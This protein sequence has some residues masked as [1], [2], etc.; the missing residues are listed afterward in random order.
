MLLA[1]HIGAAGV[2]WWL[3]PGGFP[4]SSTEFWVNQAA[5]PF[6]MALLLLALLARGRVSAVILPPV[7]AM[8]PAFWMAFGISAR[9]TF[10]ESFRSL[11]MLPFLAGAALAGLWV[12]GFMRRL[13]RGWLVPVFAVAALAAGWSFP[14]TQRAAA[15]ATNPTADPP[16]MM[17]AGGD[18]RLVKL[19][20]DAQL[21]A[22]DGRVVIKRDKV[23]LNVQP[24][25]T[26]AD[27]SPDRCW[28]ALA[29]DELNGATKR[30]FVAKSHDGALWRLWYKDEGESALDVGAR[31]GG[32]DLD[33]RCRLPHALFTHTN[34]WAELSL[35]G[36][37]KL[38]LAFSPL[39]QQRVEVAPATA[40]ERFAYVDA[41]GQFHL[42]QARERQ[43]G[44]F[45]EIAAAP[46]GK[47]PLT[48]TIFDDGKPIFT[49]SLEDFA[50]QASTQLSPT[51]GWGVPVNAIEFMRGGD[52]E[53]A[54][55]LITFTLAATNIGRGTA[56]VGHAAG[57]Y[58]NRI[59]VRLP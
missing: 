9:L 52:A 4:S 12:R 18:R 19:S 10:F 32:V 2:W 51:A 14:G 56:S 26:F 44:P 41:A 30:S 24:L 5:P 34:S 58:R 31:D 13:V 8:I 59:S 45:S 33:V 21:H 36:H 55:A 27:R 1:L 15:P 6:V 22:D 40:A 11:W 50:T 54:P 37:K 38:T 7:L 28:V 35:Q 53:S 47:Q 43:R 57:I 23:I 29:P 42:A 48:I 39:P 46:I 25:L 3:M 20:R 49:V 17:P 16:A